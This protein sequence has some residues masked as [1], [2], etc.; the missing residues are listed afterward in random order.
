VAAPT[1]D[2]AGE[3]SCHRVRHLLGF[4][5]DCLAERLGEGAHHAKEDLWPHDCSALA[6]S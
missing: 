6:L 1:S 4:R 5:L 3:K 2:H